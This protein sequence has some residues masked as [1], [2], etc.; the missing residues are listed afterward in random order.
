M[1]SSIVAMEECS[2]SKL[3]AIKCVGLQGYTILFFIN[4]TNFYIQRFSVENASLRT[5]TESVVHVQTCVAAPACALS[6]CYE[7]FAK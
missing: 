1:A 5:N 3:F 6:Q 2:H 4:N 7:P